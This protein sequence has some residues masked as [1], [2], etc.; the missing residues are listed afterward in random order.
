MSLVLSPALD[1]ETLRA[2]FAAKRRLRIPGVLTPDSAEAL[3]AAMESF[4]DWRVSVSAGG[5]LFELPLKD[6]RA[7]EPGKQSWIDNVR[8]DGDSPR[9]QYVFDTRRLTVE[10]VPD[11][12]P[13]AVSRIPAFLNSP[14]FIA[15][16][17]SVTG[18]DRIDFADAQATRFRPGHVLTTHTDA[19]DGK[20]RLYAYVLNLTREWYA[21]WGGALLFFDDDGH[22]ADG[23]VPTFNALNIFEVPSAHAVGQVSSFAPKDRLS[24]TGWLRSNGPV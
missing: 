24:I 12:T 18:D 5:E 6:R 4:D 1:I 15:F 2:A 20:N 22:V 21:D 16:V 9:M 11:H 23:F 7:A 14:A 17:R 19:V 10:G 8:V 3:T 13:D